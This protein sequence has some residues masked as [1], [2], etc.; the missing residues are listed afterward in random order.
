MKNLQKK[1]RLLSLVLMTGIMLWGTVLSVEAYI[2]KPGTVNEDVILRQNADS[3]SSQVMELSDGKEVKVNNEISGTDGTTWYQLIVDKKHLGYVPASAVT[4]SGDSVVPQ[5][6]T[7]QTVQTVTITERIGTVTASSPIRVRQDATT[8]S[9]QIASM[10]PGDT[11][12]VL[13]DVDASD[14]YVWY[15]VEFDDHGTT[16]IGHVRS[17]L[18]KVEEVTREEEQIVEVPVETPPAETVDAPY[19]INSQV[20]A[21]GTTVWYLT[22]NATG[23]AKEI[24]SL[25]NAK[26]VETKGN[27][28]YKII[29]VILLILVI[30]AAGAAT[31]FYMRWRDA[32]EFISELR[33]KQAR[34]KK[35]SVSNRSAQTGTAQT[36]PTA[37]VRPAA[38][39]KPASQTKEAGAANGSVPKMTLPENNIPTRP[40]AP[41]TAQQS[42]SQQSAKSTSQAVT[43]VSGQPAKP[44]S[45][46]GAQQ[47]VKTASQPV[48]QQPAAQSKQTSGQTTKSEVLP[49]TMDIVKATQQELKNSTASSAAKQQSGGWKSKNFL[50]DDDDLEFDFL[51][52]E[53]K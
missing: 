45:Q 46:P 16:V 39:T 27:G 34:A 35:Q 36:K 42:V 23:D 44:T 41:S 25:L 17:D 29:V 22:D 6:S 38:G 15:K 10:E 11:F 13:E 26:P 19:S 3:S 5:G 51:D 9:E 47:S 24:S 31:F 40:T 49:D 4:I 28:T 37:G 30:L 18:V 48:A 14:G 33:E 7:T 53:D 8:A 50:T 2:Q 52:M 12:L 32:E 21:E 1:I 20:N 43:G